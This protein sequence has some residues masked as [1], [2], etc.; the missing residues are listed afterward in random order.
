MR[1]INP[2]QTLQGRF[3]LYLAILIIL[4]TFIFALWNISRE[5]KLLKDAIINEAKVLVE[6]LAI[7]CTNTMLYEEIGLVDE[8]G[9]LDNYISDLMQRKDLNIL[10]A[11]ILDPK[12]KII[13]HNSLKE[14]GRTFNDD[15]TRRILSS[16]ET[17]VQYISNEILDIS[18]PLSISTKRWG[19][20]RIGISLKGLKKEVSLLTKKYIFFTSLFILFAIIFIAFLFRQ[21][22]KPLKSLASKMDEANLDRISYSFSPSRKDEI[23]ILQKSFYNLLRRIKEY[24]K[25][26]EKTQRNLI[27]T[28]KMAAIGKLTSGVAHEI[29]NPLGGLL[30]CVYHFKR[31]D[32]SAERQREYL[33]LMEEGIK[34]IQKTVTNLLEYAHTPYIEKTPID[35][36]SIID[37]SL[38]LL[39]HEIIKNRIKVVKEVSENLPIIELDKNQI[40]QV[41]LNLFL[42]SIQAMENGGVLRIRM[43]YSNGYIIIN[44]SDTGKG[45]PEDI[46]SKVFDPFFT[47]K[48]RD[49]GTGLG[50]W[51]TQTIIDRHGG[52]IQLSSL[53]GKGTTVEIRFP[54]DIT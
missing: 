36:N 3:T 4:S 54:I 38:S 19:T 22:T 49:K 28:E 53:E 34:R 10:Y 35:L 14:V 44:I 29:N 39:E 21:I 41:F 12:G 45:I 6:S 26:K 27:F 25:E 52:T 51:I 5:K 31:G 40:S 20:L 16:Y 23:G 17:S 13:A 48:G 1:I 11:M 7:S 24:E 9:L 15:Y 32:L 46:I 50:L 37:K 2:F 18:T 47:T 42:N 8:G 43:D 30:N 33:Q